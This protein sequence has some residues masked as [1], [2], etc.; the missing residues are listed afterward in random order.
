MFTFMTPHL[1]LRKPLNPEKTE[2]RWRRELYFFVKGEP[3]IAYPQF[4][5]EPAR[6]QSFMHK[7]DLHFGAFF[8]HSTDRVT[9]QFPFFFQN[10]SPPL[11]FAQDLIFEKLSFVSNGRHAVHKKPALFNSTW[12]YFCAHLTLF[13]RI[14]CRA[15]A[16]LLHYY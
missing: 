12:R 11:L 6:R 4:Y 1:R 16:L 5:S 8:A 7:R 15:L 10:I 9:S 14:N 2:R 13:L 3:F